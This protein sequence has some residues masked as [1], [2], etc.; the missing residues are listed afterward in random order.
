M[1]IHRDPLSRKVAA[2]IERMLD[3][4]LEAPLDDAA[5]LRIGLD[6]AREILAPD[7]SDE[8]EH[9]P[10]SDVVVIN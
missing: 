6:A 7:A 4:G 3:V 10:R 2:M 9:V 8:H 1:S 5:S